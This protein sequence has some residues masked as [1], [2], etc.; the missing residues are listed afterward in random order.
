MCLEITS[1]QQGQ[2]IEEKVGPRVTC[3]GCRG[4]ASNLV[5]STSM[6]TARLARRRPDIT[7]LFATCPRFAYI[8]DGIICVIICKTWTVSCMRCPITTAKVLFPH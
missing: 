3:I 5:L 4:T 1:I 6:A 8:E 2:H 7:Q